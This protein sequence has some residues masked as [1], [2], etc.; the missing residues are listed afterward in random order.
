MSNRLTSIIAIVVALSLFNSPINQTPESNPDDDVRFILQT[1]AGLAAYANFLDAIQIPTI[2]PIFYHV[3]IESDAFILGDYQ[4]SG[5]AP[6][7][8]VKLLAHRDGWIMAFHPQYQNISRLYDCRGYPYNTN[9][10]S[11]PNRLETALD[12]VATA[13]NVTGI[14]PKYYD[15]RHPEADHITLHWLLQRSFGKIS[16]TITPPLTNQYLEK[17]FGFCTITYYGEFFLNSESIAGGNS[18]F[19]FG[20]LKDH[21]LRPGFSNT[22]EV[23]QGL[24]FFSDI[25]LLGGVATIYQGEGEVSSAGG[26]RRDF[27]LVYPDMIGL[28]IEI[29]SKYLPLV[30]RQQ[31]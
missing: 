18:V 31:N 30:S 11:M 19:I 14:D 23:N 8:G 5:R 2:R 15:F 24:I 9:P 13:L 25:G 26:Y 12:E 22:L 3:D 17:A 29:H 6:D 10:T 1:Q 20:L 16:A 27:E 7:D 4:L 21:Q 28:P